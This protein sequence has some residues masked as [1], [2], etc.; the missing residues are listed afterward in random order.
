MLS[1][2]TSS[3]HHDEVRDE[4][5]QKSKAHHEEELEE[6]SGLRRASS[7][8]LERQKVSEHKHFPARGA[9]GYERNLNS[10]QRGISTAV[11]HD[12]LRKLQFAEGGHQLEVNHYHTTTSRSK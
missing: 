11:S 2:T 7:L 6:E 8:D 12:E 10:R 1:V 3:K 9:E 5:L 4:L